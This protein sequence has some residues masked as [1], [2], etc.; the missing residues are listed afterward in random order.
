MTNM[1]AVELRPAHGGGGLS[2]ASRPVPKPG[3]GEVLVRVRAASL[4]FR[5]LLVADHMYGALPE[6][7]VPLSDGAGEIAALG[8]GVSGLVPGQRVAGAFYPD[9]IT[10]PITAAARTRSLGAN[11][12]GMLAQYALLP[13]HAAIPVPDHLSD[14][15]AATLPCAGLT[16]WNALF[17]VAAL[18]PGQDVLLI[19]SGGVSVFALQFA[20]MAGARI[21]ILSGSAEKRAR[22]AEMG[23]HHLIDYKASPD[24]HK[25]V[26]QLTDGRGV[27][28]VVEVGGP[29]T[30]E[31]SMQS[32][33]VGGTIVAIG[34]VA[35]EGAGVAP[36]L[37]IGKSVNLQGIT[38][39]NC[40]QF[41]EMNRALSLHELKPA[42]GHVFA[43]DD[44]KDAY[45][46]QR[47]AGHFGKIVIKVD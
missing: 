21:I 17:N 1:K 44:V 5:D 39:G 23:A 9:W 33:R 30:L 40:A 7:V 31:K 6:T 34:F 20:R 19:G 36:R 42:I 2:I 41:H 43:M 28:V 12:D 15:E 10:G 45:A 27:D 32:V 35:Q 18:Q 4:N 47:R 37:V 13:A 46:L 16:A 22:L 29:G 24:W 38:V 26:M 8:E 11:M 14:E 25:D 3:R